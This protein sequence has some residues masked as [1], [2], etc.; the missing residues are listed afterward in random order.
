MQ[1][2]ISIHV[3]LRIALSI[4]SS[5]LEYY[6]SERDYILSPTGNSSISRDTVRLFSGMQNPMNAKIS[7]DW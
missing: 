6:I 2:Q 5:G 7:V 3:I 1:K 4:R